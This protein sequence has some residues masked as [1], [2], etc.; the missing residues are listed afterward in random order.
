MYLIVYRPRDL[1][2]KGTYDI[3]EYNIDVN[4][5]LNPISNFTLAENIKTGANVI[6]VG[7]IIEVVED[8]RRF[9]NQRTESTVLLKETFV[10]K[11]Y[12]VYLGVVKAITDEHVFETAYI[13]D[14]FN[15]KV[16]IPIIKDASEII[17]AIASQNFEELKIPP[18]YSMSLAGA[19]IYET[20]HGIVN[21]GKFTYGKNEGTDVTHIEVSVLDLL[22][23][24]YKQKG[25]VLNFKL[26]DNIHAYDYA[27]HPD[28]DGKYHYK[29]ERYLIIQFVNTK[30]SYYD[31]LNSDKLP[32]VKD[33]LEAFTDW[34]IIESSKVSNDF[35]KVTVHVAKSDPLETLGV[36]YATGN[37][38]I[39]NDY[40]SFK[41]INT[42][43]D[44][45]VR[46][47]FL[48]YDEINEKLSVEEKVQGVIGA[49]NN[50]KIIKFSV[51]F[52]KQLLVTRDTFTLGQSFKI[53]LGNNLHI[54]Q[55]TGFKF[56]NASDFITYTFGSD[57]ENLKSKLLSLKK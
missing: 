27:L 2:I 31:I 3:Q 17:N 8:A 46:P 39:V 18:L 57:K 49:Y 53:Y 40:E 11:K 12:S 4:Y 29:E 16:K 37:G 1:T 44:P 45:I 36:F 14:I 56:N 25:T 20:V 47:T 21:T 13:Y 10:A 23:E 48:E 42:E 6:K 9:E 24:L 22:I 51:D 34:E 28:K 55:L 52:S 32:K 30:Y 7:D 15:F 35:N 33:N 19:P 38:F 5:T 50:E 41:R 43:E 26:I 54:T